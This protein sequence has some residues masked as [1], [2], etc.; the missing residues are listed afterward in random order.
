MILK[1]GKKLYLVGFRSCPDCIAYQKSEFDFLHKN[2]IDTRVITYVRRNRSCLSEKYI[3]ADLSQ[4]KNWTSIPYKLHCEKFKPQH[5]KSIEN[6]DHY[7]EKNRKL[8]ENLTE[9]LAQKDWNIEV[10]ALFW[11]NGKYWYFYLGNNPK[12]PVQIQKNLLKT[13]R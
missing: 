13:S 10:P 11:E 12:A 4:N 5:I 8:R 9:I 7:L 6:I 2:Q 3:A 1:L